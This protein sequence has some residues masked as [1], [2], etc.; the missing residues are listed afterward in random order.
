MN[1]RP[2]DPTNKF[3]SDH[4]HFNASAAP[5]KKQLSGKHS[6]TPLKREGGA[7]SL[8]IGL[9]STAEQSRKL[10]KRKFTEL[11]KDATQG[12]AYKY[13]RMK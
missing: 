5:A 11:T 3:N 13:L 7:I 6:V 4:L 10:G 9:T 8:S 2:S 1:I 12:L